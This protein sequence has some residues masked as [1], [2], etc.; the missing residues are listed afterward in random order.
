MLI[1]VVSG[2]YN[3]REK[4]VND[5]L[6]YLLMYMRSGVSHRVVMVCGMDVI[7]D[8][9]GGDEEEMVKSIRRIFLNEHLD[10]S[11]DLGYA[12]ML[13]RREKV[14]GTRII[15]FFSYGDPLR[16]IKCA[17]TARSLS[18]PIDCISN[19]EES[20]GLWGLLQGEFLCLSGGGLFEFLTGKLGISSLEEKKHSMSRRCRCH[21]DLVDV[22]YLCPICLELYC[23]LIPI[24]KWCKRKF[25]F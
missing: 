11:L 14:S 5:L 6:V 13:G 1:L 8:S 10:V 21:G 12:L 18:I 3:I 17:F 7:Y 25:V 19:S 20:F 24:C 23:K 9:K 15:L 22:G 16:L 2:G 4:D